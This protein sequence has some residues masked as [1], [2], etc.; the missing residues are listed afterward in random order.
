M[1]CGADIV[2]GATAFVGALGPSRAIRTTGAA[3]YSILVSALCFS[4][5][6]KKGQPQTQ[7]VTTT[8]SAT[9]GEAT[10]GAQL[11]NLAENSEERRNFTSDS[12]SSSWNYDWRANW[13]SMAFSKVTS[14]TTP[15]RLEL[16]GEH[17]VLWHTGTEWAALA[18]SCPHRLAP[19]SEGRIDEFGQIEC[20]YHG[21]TFTQE[22]SCTKIP[23]D[24]QNTSLASCSARSYRVVERQGIIFLWGNVGASEEE[25]DTSLVPVCPAMEDDR[26]TWID[27]SRDLPYSADMLLENVLDSSHVCFTHDS[28]ISKRENAFPLPLKVTTPIGPAGFAGE[29]TADVPI[30]KVGEANAKNKRVTERKT[31]FVAP[32][33]MNHKIRSANVDDMDFDRGFE[34][35][36]VAYATPTGP[37]RS[38]LLARFP[39]RFPPPKRRLFGRFT[40]NLPALILKFLPDWMNH[41]GQLKVTDDDNIF[42]PIQERHVDDVGG[43][44]KYQMPTDSDA[45]V[46]GFRRWYDKAG[47]PPHSPFAIDEF[48]T[49]PPSK[50]QLLDRKSQHTDHCASCS[51]ALKNA[52]RIRGIMQ[53]ALLACVAAAPSLALQKA[54]KPLGGLLVAAGVFFQMR[55]TAT[56]VETSLTTGVEDY[57][58]P[59]N[60]PRKKGRAELRTVEQGRGI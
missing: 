7:Q 48:R 21:W 27:F 12:L 32:T 49:L 19:L 30:G 38:R 13:Y 40:L 18:D 58:P 45:F 33:Y 6:K 60:R 29:M 5:L 2:I 11:D 54:R 31:D 36:T 1:I 28:T 16:F 59:R 8:A 22:G 51:G 42:L 23:Q 52:S 56:F 4:K 41:M 34:T 17:L 47:P 24:T 37:G 3:F 55:K 43:W 10:T 20:P 9:I 44:K 39:F 46:R 35:W 25:A 15:H 57:P 53:G 50:E 14:K 26:F